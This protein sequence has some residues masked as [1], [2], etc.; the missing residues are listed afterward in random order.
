MEAEKSVRSKA[1]RLKGPS[2][3]DVK[4]SREPSEGLKLSEVVLGLDMGVR[5]AD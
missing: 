1:L 4:C 5:L 2:A 3:G